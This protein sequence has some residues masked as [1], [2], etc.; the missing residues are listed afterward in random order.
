RQQ[1]SLDWRVIANDGVEIGKITQSNPVAAGSLDGSWGE[2]ADIAAQ[3]AAQGIDAL[4]R[5]IDW[6]R[7]GIVRT[8]GETRGLP[9]QTGRR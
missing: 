4:I 5:K 1:A 2:I 6:R 7:R 9:P 8:T 3:G